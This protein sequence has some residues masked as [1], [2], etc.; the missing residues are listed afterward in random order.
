MIWEQRVH[1]IVMITNLVE[2]GRRKCDMY[3]PK[4]GTATYGQIDVTLVKE[5]VRANYT[6]R[7]MRVKHRK[8]K[9]KKWICSEREV[10]QFHYTG[11][12]D[13]GTPEATLPVLSFI[14]KSV[15][16]NPEDGGPIIVHCS[17][18]VGRTGT[19]I[20]I[21]AMMK[22]AAAKNEM[23]IFGFLKHIRSQR[24]HLVQTEEQYIFLHDALVEFLASG[25]TEV[26]LEDISDHI[27]SLAQPVSDFEPMTRLE[28]QYS[29]VVTFSP[30]EYDIIA[31]RKSYNETKNRAHDLVPIE[32]AK[33]GLTPKPCIEGSDYINAS[34]LQG[35][36]KLKEFI[37]T[38]HPSTETRDAF[39]SML[40]DHNAQTVVLLSPVDNQELNVFWPG[41][42]EEYDQECFRVRFIEEQIH[43]GHSTLD[44]VVSSR[45]DD[46]ELKVR[47][48]RC[49]GWPHSSS[50]L[51]KVLD[52]VNLV[53]E[54]H[55]EYQNGPLVVVDR[56]GGTEAATFCALTTLKK[57]IDAENRVDVYQVCKLY[58]NKRPGIWRSQDDYLYIYRVLESLAGCIEGETANCLIS[59]TENLIERRHSRL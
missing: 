47:M 29:N 49:A 51:Y 22:Q 54:W 9:K 17:A 55:L 50:P 5:E 3:W 37:V 48:I 26:A 11:W 46:Y 58:H 42:N 41:H 53:Q 32:I 20:V 44:F 4:E 18:G 28:K 56:F 27:L 12:P 2:R 19:Y 52:V 7:Q 57:Q 35:Y 45:Y 30:S 33:V 15:A 36:E 59:D 34:W 38:Q 16:S 24:N 21:D 6:L 13:H 1:V 10:N 8:L 31:A 25:D 40:W 23:N 39:W 14:R 43:E